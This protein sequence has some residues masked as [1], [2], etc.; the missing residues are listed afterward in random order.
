MKFAR[1]EWIARLQSGG[2]HLTEE[3]IRLATEAGLQAAG[4]SID[5]LAEVHDRLRGVK[6]SFDAAFNALRLFQKY[7][8][9][10]KR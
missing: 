3:R 7:G 1:R 6:G 10:S 9:V 5:G 8:L 4:V 2:L